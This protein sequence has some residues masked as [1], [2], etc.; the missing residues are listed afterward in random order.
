[1]EWNLHTYTPKFST[2]AVDYLSSI[3]L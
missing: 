3:M 1:M 2:T